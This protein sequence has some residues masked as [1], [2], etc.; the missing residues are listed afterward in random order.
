MVNKESENM[1][2]GYIY[3][4]NNSKIHS[5]Y[6]GG[7]ENR[8]HLIIDIL[9]ERFATNVFEANETDNINSDMK[10]DN[11]R[12]CVFCI[13]SDYCVGPHVEE[14]DFESFGEYTEMIKDDL[15]YLS[16][17]TIEDYAKNNNIDLSDL[18]KL[19]L[20]TIKNRD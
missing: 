10:F 12:F 8:I 19:V 14:K 9:P 1:A 3:E 7:S 4:I 15:A 16:H 13:T 6:N 20:N 11:Q 5:V 2:E 17:K 18:S